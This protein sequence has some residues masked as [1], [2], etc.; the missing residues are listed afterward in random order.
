MSGGSGGDIGWWRRGL[1]DQG[2]AVS[3]KAF[4]K[5]AQGLQ[6]A[7]EVTQENVG[8]AKLHIPT[9]QPTPTPTT[10]RARVR[11]KLPEMIDNIV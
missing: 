5:I 6:E 2:G 8:N 1:F 10:A 4:E 7:L 3:K 9:E 11:N